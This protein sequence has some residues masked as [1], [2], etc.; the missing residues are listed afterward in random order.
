MDQQKR[1]LFLP[2]LN[3]RHVARSTL[4]SLIRESTTEPK[5]LDQIARI[6]FKDMDLMKDLIRHPLVPPATLIFLHE[7][8]SPE[9]QMDLKSRLDSLPASLGVYKKPSPSKQGAP[10]PGSKSEPETDGT[11]YQRIRQMTVSEKI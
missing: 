8:G 4:Q 10:H 11:V 7:S 5:L 9:I 3:L 2:P 6:H 1:V